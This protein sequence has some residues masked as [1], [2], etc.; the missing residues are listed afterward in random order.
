MSKILDLAWRVVA[1]S[2]AAAIVS[3]LLNGGIMGA[4]VFPSPKSGGGVERIGFIALWLCSWLVLTA[5]MTWPAILSGLRG[6]RLV[7]VLAI[8]FFGLRSLLCVIEAAVFLKTYTAH[9]AA[10]MVFDGAIEAVVISLLLAAAMGKL[11]AVKDGATPAN[12]G[13]ATALAE[14]QPAAMPW[15]QWAWKILFCAC[16]YVVLYLVAGAIIWPFVQ[17]YYPELPTQGIG[18]RWFLALQLR[19]GLVFVVV[20]LPLVRSLR[21][22]RWQRV[23]AMAVFVP[24]VHGLAGL[25][26]PNQQMPAWGMRSAHMIEI[27]WSNFVF[28]LLVA[29]L[30]SPRPA[31]RE[32]ATE[33]ASLN[34]APHSGHIA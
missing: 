17:Q 13:S 4:G 26:L 16:A 27:G 22:P 12:S 19:R 18:M 30:F 23:L 25:L 8:A 9:D 5:A 21:G 31:S 1:A 15:L 10:F 6:L 7:Q 33:K 3:G 14:D 11:G 20:L 29:Y 34:S 2:A 28:G 32:P 24:L